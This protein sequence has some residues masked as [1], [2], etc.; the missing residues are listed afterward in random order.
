[1]KSYSLLLYELVCISGTDRLLFNEMVMLPVPLEMVQKVRLPTSFFFLPLFVAC[2][3][4]DVH[5]ELKIKFISKSLVPFAENSRLTYHIM[6]HFFMLCV[7]V[8]SCYSP[9][10]HLCYPIAVA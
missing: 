2:V 1:M 6:G 8:F 5:P 10:P 4:F 3:Y 7:C 9:T